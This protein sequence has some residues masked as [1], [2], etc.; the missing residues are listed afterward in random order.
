MMMFLKTCSPKRKKSIVA[1][2]SDVDNLFIVLS[3]RQV[4]KN[5]TI[6]NCASEE[7]SYKKIKIVGID[8]VIT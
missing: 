7:P 6:I 4:N 2:P 8:N 3:A 5:Q 1:L